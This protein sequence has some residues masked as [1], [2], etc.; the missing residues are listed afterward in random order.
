MWGG[1]IG[2]EG[3]EGIE[4]GHFGL[5]KIYTEFQLWVKQLK[6]RGIIIAVCSKNTEE[7]AKAP[8]LAHPDMV[9]HIDDIAVFLA[10]WEN[11]ADNI[12]YLQSVLNIGFDSMV[13]V[14]DSRFEREMVRSALPE[15]TVPELPEDPAEYLL[16][17]RT[18][19]LFETAS[20]TEEDEMRTRHYQQ[21][22]ERNMLLPGFDNRD[23][24]LKDLGMAA[25]VRKLDDFTIPRVAQL[26]QR[27]NQFNLRTVRYT[28]ED[29]RRISKDPQYYVMS[30]SLKDR[31]GDHGLVGVVILKKESE[32]T[33]FIDSWIMSC[34]VLKRGMENFTLNVIAELAAANN[35]K[36]LIGEYIPT[37]KN[38]IVM[39][40]YRD[41]GF[42]SIGDGWVLDVAGYKRNDTFI[43]ANITF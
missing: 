32:E 2:D 10:N 33:L 7:V 29:L 36:K 15:I 41:L 37:K 8:F 19:N 17:L 27:S 5:G 16:Y 40:H 35:F 14:D 24:F 42:E 34:R 1:V 4:L 6:E 11:K 23:D 25:E 13:F 21:A 3:M 9:L 31:F 18:L 20:Y 26:T 38:G 30:L 22:A 39:D 28:E 43:N 12:R